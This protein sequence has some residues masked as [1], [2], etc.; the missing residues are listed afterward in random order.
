MPRWHA[1]SLVPGAYRREAACRSRLR[2]LQE[3]SAAV[4]SPTGSRRTDRQQQCRDAI[5]RRPVAH[6]R[7]IRP[8]IAIARDRRSASPRQQHSGI[9]DGV[10]RRPQQRRPD[11]CEAD[12]AAGLGRAL[13]EGFVEVVV[14]RHAGVIEMLVF[15][16]E[17]HVAI[18]PERAQEREGTA[19][20]RSH[21]CATSPRAATPEP[22]SRNTRICGHEPWRSDAARGCGVAVADALV[23]AGEWVT[24]LLQGQELEQLGQV[25]AGMADH[26]RDDAAANEIDGAPQ[27]AQDADRQRRV[28]A[29]IDM[30]EAE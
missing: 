16:L 26:G 19:L 5:D 7:D 13:E 28:P 30:A 27:R 15:V 6:R 12:A 3:R 11:G 8:G 20:R 29:L 17:R 24:S 2:A 9:G 10:E 14:P 21:R 4:P 25:E 23:S 22:R 18:E 1:P